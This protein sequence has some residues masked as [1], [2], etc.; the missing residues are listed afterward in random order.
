MNRTKRKILVCE[1]WSTL[2]MELDS[3]T[4][5]IPEGNVMGIELF[6]NPI[7]EF[8]EKSDSVEK[9][10]MEYEYVALITYLEEKI[11]SVLG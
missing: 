1:S 2:E 8:K 10:S 3:F 9:T 6:I 7:T 4:S 11:H 5:K